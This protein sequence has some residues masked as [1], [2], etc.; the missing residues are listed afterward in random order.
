MSWIDGLKHRARTLFN[1]GAYDREMDDEI[2]HHIDLGAQAEGDGDAARRRFGN[3]TYHKEEAR[4]ATWLSW[5]DVLQQDARYAWRSLSRSPAFTLTVVLTL[6]LGIGANGAMFSFL[7]RMFVRPPDGVVRPAE[8]RR[9]WVD[10]TAGWAGRQRYAAIS[11]PT[12]QAAREAAGET[13]E[14]ALHFPAGRFFIGRDRTPPGLM[15]EYATSNLFKVLGVKPALGRFFAPDE[16]VMGAGTQVV[17]LSH[18]LWSGRFK[19]DSG[20]LGTTLELGLRKFTVIGVASREFRGADVQAAD[21][22]LPLATFVGRQQ[23]GREWWQGRTTYG[24]KAILR[25]TPQFDETRF[26]ARATTT[27]RRTEL[28]RDPVYGDSLYAAKLGPIVEARGPGNLSQDV[29]MATRLGGVALIVLV[30]AFANVVGLLLARA[31]TRQREIALR[32]ALGISRGRLVRLLT[33]ETVLLSLAAAAAALV[34]SA[35]G[36]GVLRALLL[37]NINWRDSV[38][39]GRVVFFTIGVALLAGLLAGIVPA[40][41]ATSVSLGAIKDVNVGNATRA[42]KLRSTFVV[43]QAAFSVVLV[44]TGVLFVRSLQNVLAIP[45]GVDSDRLLF[46]TVGF[47]A[48]EAPPDSVLSMN[49]RM[50]RPRIESRPGVEG[51]ARAQSAPMRGYSYIGAFIDG[52]TLKQFGGQGASALAVSRNYFQVTGL[53]FRSGET[54][55]GDDETSA[56]RQIVVNTRMAR[57]YWPG[58]DAIGQCLHL[59]TATSPCHYVVGVVEQQPRMNVIESEQAQ[60]YLPI[61]SIISYGRGVD[62]PWTGSSLVVRARPEAQASVSAELRTILKETYPL[63]YPS[64]TP[65]NAN[66]ASEYRPWRVGARLFGWMGALALLVALVGIYSS[67]AYSVN[68]RTREFGVRI[69]LGARVRDV[70]NQVVGEGLRTVTIGVVLGVILSLAAGKL[71]ASML[72]G[73]EPDD[74]SA[75]LLSACSM[76]LIAGAAAVIPAWRAARVDPVTALRAE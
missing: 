14:V 25:V 26:L 34:A 66:L 39:D 49:A 40:L 1:P 17:V 28:E 2:R 37:P 48:G 7:D 61:G 36:G 21:L 15:G 41:Q 52:D 9:L 27:M 38:V 70:V 20:I 64:V 56:S 62:R 63:G 4:G 65:M 68:R 73:V 67:V 18:D 55:N 12:L 59:G 76:L 42:A 43:A 35:W 32:L 45:L 19:A 74:V 13:A 71:L 3:R 30:I 22:W 31:I 47:E 24:A 23:Q 51:V 5:L 53:E 10:G 54:F 69:A 44:V 72:F 60:Y 8:L 6:A 75:M 11:Y 29:V 50:L 58:R 33:T 46:A 57:L 16:D